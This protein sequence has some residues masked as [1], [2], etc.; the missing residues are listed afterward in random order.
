MAACF[1]DGRPDDKRPYDLSGGQKNCS[2]VH[3][4]N[5]IYRPTKFRKIAAVLHSTDTNRAKLRI[6]ERLSTFGF[7]PP[8]ETLETSRSCP[9]ARVLDN[10]EEDVSRG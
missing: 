8:G 6:Q 5:Y 2:S 9:T 10:M 7:I 1:E 4:S 3:A